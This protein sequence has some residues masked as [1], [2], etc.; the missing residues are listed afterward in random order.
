MP[1]TFAHVHN[2]EMKEQHKDLLLSYSIC[3]DLEQL[4]DD[5]HVERA[6][7][8]VLTLGQAAPAGPVHGGLH[9]LGGGRGGRGG[10]G[11]GAERG[12]QAGQHRA[13]NP[14]GTHQSNFRRNTRAM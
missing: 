11:G 1:C 12:Q 2:Y 4:C 14:A 7:V 5:V 13:T 8:S 6:G 9:Q 10:E 3:F